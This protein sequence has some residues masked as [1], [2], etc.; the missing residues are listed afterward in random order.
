M[1][2]Q[3]TWGTD[4]CWKGNCFAWWVF[5]QV[6]VPAQFLVQIS[7]VLF[8]LKREMESRSKTRWSGQLS[9]LLILSLLYSQI[10]FSKEW[11]LSVI[12]LCINTRKMF[13]IEMH[14]LQRRF[15][16]WFVCFLMLYFGFFLFL[17]FLREIKG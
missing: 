6:S 4:T 13:C 12:S 7:T 10:A 11:P 8:S 17:T 3:W 1:Q 2:L 5:S 15:W 14:G 16:D 9:F